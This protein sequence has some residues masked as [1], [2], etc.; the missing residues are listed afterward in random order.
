MRPRDSAID[1]KGNEE[2]SGAERAQDKAKLT[3]CID[4]LFPERK[5]HGPAPSQ[6]LRVIIPDLLYPVKVN[7]VYL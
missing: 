3:E 1:E 6:D 5:V 7:A 4:T 2:F